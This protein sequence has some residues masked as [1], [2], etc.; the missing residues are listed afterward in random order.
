MIYS[1]NHCLTINLNS[2]KYIIINPE[3]STPKKPVFWKANDCGYT[4]S[5]FIAGIYTH[6]Q[7]NG[8]PN[9]YNDGFKA[10]AIPLT[11]EAMDILGFKCSF[12]EKGLTKFFQ[13]K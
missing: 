11:D 8:N 1:R 12:D 13:R 4:Y 10:V 9:Y 6:E 5:P 2:M 3:Q 7:V